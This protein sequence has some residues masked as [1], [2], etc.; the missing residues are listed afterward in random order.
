VNG[1]KFL[2]RSIHLNN[3]NENIKTY[4]NSVLEADLCFV[5]CSFEHLGSDVIDRHR[6]ASC[7]HAK[8]T[9]L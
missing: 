9:L 2:T 3:N 7:L 1:V 6:N 8:T 4:K 5:C